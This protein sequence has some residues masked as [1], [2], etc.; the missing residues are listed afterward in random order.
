MSRHEDS[1][2][3]EVAQR[4]TLSGMGVTDITGF[5]GL[6][7]P[8]D[9]QTPGAQFQVEPPCEHLYAKASSDALAKNTR[10]TSMK[11]LDTDDCND[12]AD[13]SERELMVWPFGLQRGQGACNP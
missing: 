12:D 6:H 4:L 7:S 11:I 1:F 3:P 8:P 2:A 9:L 13:C 5:L 10:R